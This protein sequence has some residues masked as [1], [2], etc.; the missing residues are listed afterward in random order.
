MLGSVTHT[1]SVR[2]VLVVDDSG[3]SRKVLSRLLRNAGFNCFEAVDGEDCVLKV[4]QFLKDGLSIHMVFMDFE[5][6]KMNGPEASKAL[7]DMGVTV[8]IIG[9]TGNV[10][11]ADKIYFL[12][13]GANAV[14]HKP[15][16]IEQLK[17]EIEKY[18]QL[19][20]STS[21]TYSEDES[22]RVNV[23]ADENV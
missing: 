4:A 5:M 12:D 17:A 8:P 9:V 20:A 7:R 22:K 21:C 1:D 2:N 11:P 10:L 6:P 23:P 18:N 13:H 15:L 16:N 19:I 14:L 3:P